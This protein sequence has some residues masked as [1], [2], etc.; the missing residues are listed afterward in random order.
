M[1]N[2]FEEVAERTTRLNQLFRE[3]S[4]AYFP[5]E[6][7][8]SVACYRLTESLGVQVRGTPSDSTVVSTLAGEV[9]AHYSDDG[10]LS[11]QIKLF[12]DPVPVQLTLGNAPKLF[13]ESRRVQ[14]KA[15]PEL[16]KADCWNYIVL[17]KSCLKQ[18]LNIAGGHK[19]VHRGDVT[20][21]FDECLEWL[22]EDGVNSLKV[23]GTSLKHGL[24]KD[25]REKVKNAVPAIEVDKVKRCLEKEIEL[26]QSVEYRSFTAA[27]RLLMALEVETDLAVQELIG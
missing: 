18:I 22:I 8:S 27:R 12:Q 16:I 19:V 23:F 20:F 26:L 3:L 4:E 13:L 9:K 14:K 21:Y 2:V 10:L 15:L 17:D 1:A 7:V 25:V 24:L 11:A 6:Q 5:A